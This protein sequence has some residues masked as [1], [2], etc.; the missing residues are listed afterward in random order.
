M[1]LR[2]LILSALITAPFAC[3]STGPL[4]DKALALSA[5]NKDS[6][7]QLSAT[8]EIEMT[9]GDLPSK[10]EALQ[11]NLWVNCGSGRSPSV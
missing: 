8:V 2:S 1:K 11:Q 6:V 4:K 5:S 9:A 7:L 3:A 10:K